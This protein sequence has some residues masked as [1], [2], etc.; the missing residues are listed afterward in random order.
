M[1]STLLH[2]YIIVVLSFP[3]NKKSCTTV[4][5]P[6]LYLV[7]NQMKTLLATMTHIHTQEA[8]LGTSF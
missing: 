5:T 8:R 1:L 7:Q 4:L 2:A 6:M 3:S